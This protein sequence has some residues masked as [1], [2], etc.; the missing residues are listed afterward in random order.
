MMTIKNKKGALIGPINSLIV[1]TIVVALI[2]IVSFLLI[3]FI[4]TPSVDVTNFALAKSS[5]DISMKAY[6][7]TPVKVPIDGKAV[8][9]KMIELIRLADINLSYRQSLE[10]NTAEILDK[11]YPQRYYLQVLHINSST[12]LVPV[13]FVESSPGLANQAVKIYSHPIDSFSP[14]FTGE[15]TTSSPLGSYSEIVLPGNIL[16]RIFIYSK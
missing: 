9:M 8:D 14:L 5:A 12:Y 7:E 2:L 11:A 3:S 1:T 13:A 15:S 10:S 16:V 4:G 6:L